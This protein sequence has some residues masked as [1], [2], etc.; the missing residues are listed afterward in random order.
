MQSA[1]STELQRLWLDARCT[2]PSSA[3]HVEKVSAF[4]SVFVS[5]FAGRKSAAFKVLFGDGA[6]LVMLLCRDYATLAR[7]LSQESYPMPPAAPTLSTLQ[8]FAQALR[9]LIN[10]ESL[11]STEVGRLASAY[12]AYGK[13]NVV[14][15][16]LVIHE[17]FLV[18]IRAARVEDPMLN[19][20]A[21]TDALLLQLVDCVLSCRSRELNRHSVLEA[22]I[23]ERVFG[24]AATAAA[25]FETPSAAGVDATESSG[26]ILHQQLPNVL[27]AD[28]ANQ[29][30]H[31]LEDALV[32]S[33]RR[34]AGAVV[35]LYALKCFACLLENILY[36]K[37]LV[38]CSPVETV[39][40]DIVTATVL[41]FEKEVDAEG[42]PAF[43]RIAGCIRFLALA[44]RPDLSARKLASPVSNLSSS[45][46]RMLPASVS[47]VQQRIVD[48]WTGG[49]QR[50]MPQRIHCDGA[51]DSLA[52]LF[53]LSSTLQ[54][55][56]LYGQQLFQLLSMRGVPSAALR[57][58]LS[59]CA[60]SA[61]TF[62][63]EKL[64]SLL[65]FV[66]TLPC[67]SEVGDFLQAIVTQLGGSRFG[68]PEQ[69]RAVIEF[70]IDWCPKAESH[71]TVALALGVVQAAVQC[72]VGLAKDPQ[73]SALDIYAERFSV[74]CKVVVS[75]KTAARCLVGDN[76][77]ELL[78]Q[79]MLASLNAGEAHTAVLLRDAFVALVLKTELFC[80]TLLGQIAAATNSSP[81]ASSATPL[82]STLVLLIH[83]WGRHHRA[84]LP[85]NSIEL[86]LS[87]TQQV[88]S[89]SLHPAVDRHLIG[90]CLSLLLVVV[91]YSDVWELVEHTVGSLPVSCEH[92]QGLLDLSTGVYRS[93]D[94]LTVAEGYF[95]DPVES[96]E[97]WS[98]PHFA[99]FGPFAVMR[100]P[101]CEMVYPVKL[102]VRMAGTLLTE[103]HA[104]AANAVD[105][106]EY[107]LLHS[108]VTVPSAFLV[109]FIATWERFSWLRCVSNVSDRKLLP[110]F[111]APSQEATAI[112]KC[113]QRWLEALRSSSNVEGQDGTSFGDYIHFGDG[114]G[115]SGSIT[116]GGDVWPPVDAYATGM[117]V[118]VGPVTLSGR[119]EGKVVLW[120]VDWD[121][122]GK[123]F[124][125]SL[126]A[127]TQRKCCLYSCDFDGDGTVV[128]LP[129]LPEEQWVHVATTH[130]RGRVFAS[131]LKVFVN[132]VEVRRCGCPYPASGLQTAAAVASSIPALLNREVSVTV[133]SPRDTPNNNA[134]LR[135]ISFELYGCST[136]S[137]QIMS[138]YAMGPYHS[139]QAWDGVGRHQC[140][141]RVASLSDE[142]V[143]CLAAHLQ[144]ASLEAVV[145]DQCVELVLPPV[146]VL[147]SIHASA[148]GQV[149][150]TLD[151]LNNK[152]WSLRNMA[153][154]NAESSFSLHG[155]YRP[156]RGTHTNSV[157]AL[158][159][160]GAFYMWLRWMAW[161]ARES[162][163][164]SSAE[165]EKCTG[166][167]VRQVAYHLVQILSLSNKQTDLLPLSW[168]RFAA[169]FSEHVSHQPRIYLHDPTSIT[170]LLHVCVK[171]LVYRDKN[172]RRTEAT[173][174]ANSLLL[175]HI[176]FD[177]KLL[178]N[179]PQD[180]WLIVMTTLRQLVAP[181]NALAAFNT[182]RL[183]TAD[184]ING[185][186]IGLLREY[187]AFPRLLAAVELMKAV[188]LTGQATEELMER[189]LTTCLLTVPCRAGP[190]SSVSTLESHLGS[191][192]SVTSLAYIVLV[193]NMLLR[194]LNEVLETTL[195]D[196]NTAFLSAFVA[197]VPDWW[198]SAM[199]SANSHPISATLSLRLLVLCFLNSKAFREGMT[200]TRATCMAQAMEPHCH[201]RELMD[202]LVHGYMG[203]LWPVS[204]SHAAYST[205]AWSGRTEMEGLLVLVLH[206]LKSQCQLLLRGAA[207]LSEEGTVRGYFSGAATEVGCTAANRSVRARQQWRRA[208]DVLRALRRLRTAAESG[209]QREVVNASC[210]E[211]SASFTPSPEALK[212]SICEVMEW[213]TLSYRLSN[214][215]RKSLYRSNS[216]SNLID[217]LMWPVLVALRAKE[218]VAAAAS[219]ANAASVAD[220]DGSPMKESSKGSSGPSSELDEA[221]EWEVL[222]DPSTFETRSFGL[223]AMGPADGMDGVYD[224]CKSFFLT[225]AASRAATTDIL[226]L[227]RSHTK[228]SKYV[229][230]LH[231]ALSTEVKG[232]GS[233]SEDIRQAFLCFV[234]L[235]ASEQ[236][237]DR[238]SDF[239][240]GPVKR[241]AL[242]LGKYALDRLVSGSA[243]PPN[244]V[245]GFY[246]FLLARVE[247]DGEVM[248]QSRTAIFEWFMYITSASFYKLEAT[249]VGAVVDIV[250]NCVDTLFSSP[251]PA[252]ELLKTVVA[253]MLQVTVC[254][255]NGVADDAHPSIKKMATLWKAVLTANQSNGSLASLFCTTTPPMDLFRG[256]FDRLLS[257]SSTTDDFAAWLRQHRSETVQ[258]LQTYGG[259]SYTFLMANGVEYLRFITRYTAASVADGDRQRRHVSLLATSQ[260]LLWT[261]MYATTT[262]VDRAL[263]TCAASRYPNCYVLNGGAAAMD[264]T[265]DVCSE[266]LLNCSGAVGKC[267]RYVSERVEEVASDPLNFYIR[268]APPMCLPL[269]RRE[270]QSSTVVLQTNA[271][272]VVAKVA[273]HGSGGA[274]LFVCNAY[275]V[276]GTESYI[277]TTLLT[278]EEL[279]IVTC[280]AVTPAG[281]FFVE[282]VRVHSAVQRS[283]AK[284]SL[285]QQALRLFTS[286]QGRGPGSTSSQAAFRY[287]QYYRQLQTESA[288]GSTA[289]VWR[290]P[291]GI[292]TSVHQRLFQHLSAGLEFVMESGECVFLVLLDDELSFSKA[293]RDQLFS[294]FDS[295]F[296]PIIAGISARSFAEKQWALAVWTR[297]W[298][299]REC[300]NYTYLCVL[301][302]AASRS[303]AYLGQYPVMPWTLCS[304][305]ASTLDLGDAGAYRDL[306]KPVGALNEVKAK[307]LQKR[308]AEWISAD[309]AT[310]PPYHYG[311]HYSTA[312]IVLYFLV[313]LQPFTA[314]SIRFQGGKL[315][316]ADRL[317]HS[318]A[319]AWV[320]CSG[321]GSGDVK[322]L[323]PEF[324]RV[325]AFLQNKNGIALGTCSDGETLGDVVLPPWCGGSALAFVYMNALSLESEVVSGQLHK[326][327]D[328][329]FGYKQVGPAAVEAIN[330]FSPLSYKEGVDRAINHAAT[331]EERRSIVASADNFG[332]TPLQLFPKEPHPPRKDAAK[333][334]TTQTAMLESLTDLTTRPC[335][336]AQL[337]VRKGEQIASGLFCDDT[338]FL[339]DNTSAVGSARPALL[340]SYQREMDRI[341]CT[342]LRGDRVL[343]TIDQ[344]RASGCGPVRCICASTRGSVV[345]VGTESGRVV[346]YSRETVRHRFFIIAVLD[347]T[348]DTCLAEAGAVAR[349]DLFDEG[350]LVVA[351]EGA[352][353]VS[354]WHLSFLSTTFSF[355]ASLATTADRTPV[356]AISRDTHTGL[357]YA[358][359]TDSV[360][361]FSSGGVVLAHHH[362]DTLLVSAVP[363]HAHRMANACVTALFFANCASF[364]F[365]NLLLLGHSDGMVSLW[366]VVASQTMAEAPDVAR[367]PLWSFQFRH[368]VV[369][370]APVTCLVASTEETRFI[371]GLANGT[372]Q[373]I[374]FPSVDNE[375][376]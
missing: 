188:L 117:W 320:N 264:E 258:L 280:S 77:C 222:P 159:C 111:F 197:T 271:R 242:E 73:G 225:H 300:S 241:N 25:Y 369:F 243:V 86:C 92:V 339:L 113:Q 180:C 375:S 353:T 165:G 70:F 205:V 354:G 148:M 367:A 265:D 198:F 201:Q 323:I 131:Q 141:L 8:L 45:L 334:H 253:R 166:A 295:D 257:V 96:T 59:I 54:M 18:F 83:S 192:L 140:D 269:S 203:H 372:A 143:R 252:T 276:V 239:S 37:Q 181:S 368:A 74:L 278:P 184:F 293:S 321:R 289:L 324:F 301:N 12:E 322:E 358:A 261:G 120:Q 194:C 231:R 23:A 177:W 89:S 124:C 364:S 53:V 189:L 129:M 106:V 169:Q 273:G 114:G 302:D 291:L 61:A 249:K 218:P 10:D 333:V 14:A 93:N 46:L 171:T 82:L 303:V 112:V 72:M 75:A 237:I 160:N 287:S 244:G 246:R 373:T 1:L 316:I 172:Q 20:V 209:K 229:L 362:M 137:K 232:I 327:I 213:L 135:V 330:V 123:H 305:S 348:M 200:V 32:S 219:A 206:L 119:Q 81:W 5:C 17:R 247:G 122:A 116:C 66:G 332:Q 167:A 101:Y 78:L 248:K 313:R 349:L 27:N 26:R 228:V 335:V 79:V 288:K 304:Y 57:F 126:V 2:P 182:V 52:R 134:T 38:G 71:I 223:D 240:A 196:G 190:E 144:S 224:A 343:A 286:G 87:L 312:A 251:M 284:S 207:V 24:V 40:F 125:V 118:F 359:K 22:T 220:P 263:L 100:E 21:Q 149:S 254:L 376:S 128:E 329:I 34:V 290:F 3:Q 150:K 35:A 145:R 80:D 133:G 355:A 350:K 319:E 365:S 238:I 344:I 115:A 352:S 36:V 84:S 345:C 179:L 266:W 28:V 234:W 260:R 173:L 274:I 155:Y 195:S 16:S 314:R 214:A 221:D 340:F 191:V 183:L 204:S 7:Q 336:G 292:I 42:L 285:L 164:V 56:E 60:E 250:Y 48:S 346:V 103:Q 142:T 279:I 67:K 136:S 102:L 110:F 76:F 235:K 299:R 88:V 146:Q 226:A 185:F 170:L 233:Q 193:R 62:E 97:L 325:P 138:M 275:L 208:G 153:A 31:K 256:G 178:G 331:E 371:V 342:A 151:Y 130:S 211:P 107:L 227:A 361:V 162:Q 95:T 187:V 366:C 318:V 363:A 55:S 298:V 109:D 174:L 39:S 121:A 337:A 85:H 328:L 212:S 127:H 152:Q 268:Y 91:N 310:D 282:Q 270:P 175:E 347:S 168:R 15:L 156:P 374:S 154:A 99:H 104:D 50:E 108:G 186:V 357:Y 43:R 370:E 236:C 132:G 147:V 33:Q 311:T 215:L 139:S 259:V 338:L 202:V 157:D 315:D 51:V 296:D 294:Y 4:L 326:W 306:S 163:E 13:F 216:P 98:A 356:R 245:A 41:N 49:D 267:R 9:L 309:V 281:D 307:Q 262:F 341:V 6:D 65:S 90:C 308:Y 210:A 58:T 161:V 283:S 360:V 11:P 158:L 297:R 30:L 199:L 44:E 255:W 29:T 63:P 19:V 317:F 47:K 64:R 94:N 217:L 351:Y 105:A 272:A 277:C 176:F 230:A 68:Q 69:R